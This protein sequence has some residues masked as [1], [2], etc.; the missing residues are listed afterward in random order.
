MQIDTK[1]FEC[2]NVESSKLIIFE[3]FWFWVERWNSRV[4][5]MLNVIPR[6]LGKFFSTWKIPTLHSHLNFHAQFPNSHI[7]K[8]HIPTWESV[9]MKLVLYFLIDC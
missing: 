9:G 4:G 7:P 6:Y 2:K 8:S 1:K 3:S 5:V